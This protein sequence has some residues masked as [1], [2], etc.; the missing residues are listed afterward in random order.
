MFKHNACIYFAKGF[1]VTFRPSEV[2]RLIAK[3]LRLNKLWPGLLIPLTAYAVP[4]YICHLRSP[5]L[6]P[7][8]DPSG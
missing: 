2:L 5:G 1:A 7:T 4:I 6:G 3:G 8:T